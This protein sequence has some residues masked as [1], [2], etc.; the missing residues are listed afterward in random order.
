MPQSA[1]VTLLFTDLVNSTE[2]LQRSGD[3]AGDQFFR[4]HHR[5]TTEAIEAGGGEELQ[6]LGD[7]VL[8]AFPSAADAVRCA[9]QVQHTARRP[10]NGAK[11]DI[12]IGIHLG[13]VLRRDGGYF[14]T[15]V[16]TARRLCD[17]ADSGQIL[18]SRMVAD[19]LSSRQSFG[20]R[21]LGDQ[22]LKGL[23]SPIGVCEVIYER[24]DPVAM[25]NR[26][27]F[28]G[29]VAQLK[30]LAAKFD[31]ACHGRGGIVM[32]RGEPGIG[33]TRTLEEF[34]D[35]A[36]QRGATIMRGACY[37]G[38][39]Q[40]PF[41]PFAEMLAEY[42]RS[43]PV[44]E[45]AAVLGKRAA[46]LARIAPALREM[47]P[48]V[49][50]LPVLEKDEE[51]FR[52]F[53]A[54]AQFLITASHTATLVVILAD[55]HWADRGTVAMLS[56]VAHLIAPNPILL[57]GAYRDAEVGRAHPLSAAI[58]GIGRL[59]N[60]ETLA[61]KGIHPAELATLLEMIGDQKVPE[62]LVTALGEATQGNPLFIREVLLHLI[63]EGKILR[64]GQG[65]TSKLSIEE[66]GLPESVRQ[67]IARRLARLS[68]E[69]NRL[70]S[71]A[72]AFNGSF[73][74]EIAAAAANLDEQTALSALDEALDAQ[75]VR[76]GAS[77][78]SFD[79]THALIRHNLYRE[80]NPARR[81]RLHRKIAEE[82]ERSW[83]ERVA[84][85]AAEVAFHY[86]RGAAVG[87]AERGLEYAIAAANNAEAAYAYDDVAAFLKI[88]LELIPA[89]DPRR[90]ELLKRLGLAVTWLPEGDDAARITLE[91]AELIAASDGNE[92]A[93]E[94]LEGA[95]RE[96]IK[97]GRTQ[98]AW[99]LASVGLKY[100]GERR[101]IVWASLDEI[102]GYRSE[103]QD[104][105]NPGIIVDSPRRRER[106][107]VLR[108][109]APAELRARRMD[110]Y[111]YENR[112]E[113]V[114]DPNPD[115]ISLL[116]LGGECKRSVRIWQQRA[117][118]AERSGRLAMAMDSWAHLARAHNT[119]GHAAEAR[120]AYDRALGLSA[121]FNRPSFPLLNL[122]S[123][124]SDFFIAAGEAWDQIP[125]VSGFDEALADPP[126][127]FKFA[128]VAACAQMSMVMAFDNRAEAAMQLLA[129]LP[130]A[131]R[132]AAPWNAGF[133]VA[134]CDGTAALWALNSPEH[135]QSI[136]QAI[137]ASLL[138]ADFRFPMR[139]ARLAIACLCALQGRIEEACEW[140]AKSREILDEAGW[141]PLRAIVDYD[142][143]LMHLRRGDSG[144]A[145]PLLD[146]AVDQFSKLE[147]PG[148]FKR[149]Q[150]ALRAS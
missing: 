119:L 64:D 58:A 42:A 72:S 24:D 141:R 60:A 48:E 17:R 116:L 59:R 112:D 43:L 67:V 62:Q 19:L 138:P 115:E 107:L 99:D 122:M 47:L 61:L 79:F 74:F 92:R 3:E 22:R 106:R 35:H 23:A 75:I 130:N 70:L 105:D 108:Q 53:D 85:H 76:P 109:S 51:R 97:A 102:D 91:A 41:G 104:P 8:A 26:T 57:V 124:R 101:D 5:L 25:V 6:W 134:V 78:E 29:R 20:F 147:M 38:E 46:I 139:D 4:V 63:E 90:A 96:M 93:A 83:G 128:T 27:P 1:T 52:L 132:R 133:N 34:A 113:I 114:S 54:V 100:I 39:W 82:M 135:A 66:L 65:W 36:R 32:L 31:E 136:E 10:I 150:A 21:D 110:E 56:H 127:E 37:D 143:G 148:W 146:R 103:S 9:I 12:R 88:A 55:L 123:L 7:G 140:F 30:R 69:A 121:R 45:L 149:A 81:T 2:H 71:V 144:A 40:Q 86:W 84:N 129:L 14:G 87:G 11:F 16:V 73:A 131:L 49:G 18:C 125:T 137:R 120:A 50:E 13:E 77:S 28:V 142:E 126:M 98:A 33:K 145:Q 68:D 15:P 111:P 95:G 44:S 118:E 94:Y 80:L 117:A 89:A